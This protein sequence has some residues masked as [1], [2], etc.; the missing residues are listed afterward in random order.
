MTALFRYHLAMLL[1]SQRWLSPLLLYMVLL[2][3]GV[4]SSGGVLDS[5]GLSAAALL[6]VTAW[7]VRICVTQ[8][9]DAAR[10]VTAAATGMP[11]A[12]LAALLTATVCAAAIGLVGTAVVTAI[13]NPRRVEDL[14]D[15]TPLSAG[16]SGLLGAL[17]CL[18]T[19]VTVGALFS[20]PLLRDRGWSILLTGLFSLLALVAPGSPANTVVNDLVNSSHGGG[21]PT[22]APPLA[23]AALI[24]ALAGGAVCVLG[25]RRG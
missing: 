23:A 25:T 19:G 15:I 6:P 7:L 4:D 2:A 17:V 8:E 12:H 11:R 14:V 3:V 24:A 20:R 1:R 16:T 21:I 9:P 13:A 5:L 18:L 22:H 10:D